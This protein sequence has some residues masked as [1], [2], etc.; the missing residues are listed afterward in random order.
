M[1][2]GRREIK[3]FARGNHGRARRRRGSGLRLLDRWSTC[4]SGER[5]GGRWPGRS[6][7]CLPLPCSSPGRRVEAGQARARTA[8]VGSPSCEV[9]ILRNRGVDHVTDDQ[10]VCIPD[11]TWPHGRRA[12]AGHPVPRCVERAVRLA[13]G[14]VPDLP[15]CC[16]DAE[17]CAPIAIT[18]CGRCPAAAPRRSRT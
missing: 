11:V 18:T 1:A 8:E 2:G 5:R 15:H 14:R 17:P 12:I 10:V 4:T 6:S 16:F 3:P 9:S 7:C 13:D